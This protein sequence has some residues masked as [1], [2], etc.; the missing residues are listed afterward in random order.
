MQLRGRFRGVETQVPHFSCLH[1]IL[2][3]IHDKCILDCTHCYAVLLASPSQPV[4]N[5]P[6]LHPR[7]SPIRKTPWNM[8]A[9]G[10]WH[11]GSLCSCYCNDV[12]FIRT[13]AFPILKCHYVIL[14]KVIL[15][16][17]AYG[18]N[19]SFW[20]GGTKVKDQWKWSNGDV[21]TTFPSGQPSADPSHVYTILDQATDF[22]LKSSA[23][24]SLYSICQGKE[25]KNSPH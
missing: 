2:W 13:G 21:I 19:H 5:M 4:S 9:Y 20:A 17:P 12:R 3:Q 7:D 25:W 1:H 18:S 23:D 22:G 14:L 16:I 11:R 10:L 8:A 24:A 15:N 6:P